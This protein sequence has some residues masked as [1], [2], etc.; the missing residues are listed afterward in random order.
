MY[1]ADKARSHSYLIA[2]SFRLGNFSGTRRISVIEKPLN[3]FDGFFSLQYNT[4][5][6]VSFG[7]HLSPPSKRGE[8]AQALTPAPTPPARVRGEGGRHRHMT[9]VS[10][11]KPERDVCC[12]RYKGY[13]ALCKT[14]QNYFKGRTNPGPVRMRARYKKFFLINFEYAVTECKLHT[15]TVA[16]LVN[17][18]ESSPYA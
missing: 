8:M 13:H 10:K 17:N 11:K 5:L 4:L 12:A 2:S 6:L 15:V 7:N 18:K 1:E 14:R 16:K 9:P 3:S